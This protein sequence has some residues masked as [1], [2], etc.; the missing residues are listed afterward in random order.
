[1]IPD[2]EQIFKKIDEPIKVYSVNRVSLVNLE[3]YFN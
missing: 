1:M 3:R 2:Y